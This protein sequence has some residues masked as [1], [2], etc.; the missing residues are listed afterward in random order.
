MARAWK[1]TQSRRLEETISC[2]PVAPDALSD[3]QTVRRGVHE[4]F[5]VRV[6]RKEL[7]INHWL[8]SR[9]VSESG[10]WRGTS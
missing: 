6:F 4:G 10:K 8:L 7:L 9:S 2:N 5:Y 1:A 3:L